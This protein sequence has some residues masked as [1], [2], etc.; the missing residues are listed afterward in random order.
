[1]AVRIAART[2]MY[3]LTYLLTTLYCDCVSSVD[4]DCA[5]VKGTGYS[6]STWSTMQYYHATGF[7][8]QLALTTAV[9]ALYRPVVILTLI[10]TTSTLFVAAHGTQCSVQF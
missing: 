7:C 1:M 4:V 8:L 6:R 9:S 2:Q 3:L 10:A 5:A